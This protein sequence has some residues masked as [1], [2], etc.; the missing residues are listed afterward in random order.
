MWEATFRTG[1]GLTP[2]DMCDWIAT[3]GLPEAVTQT[4]QDNLTSQDIDA[5]TFTDLTTSENGMAALGINDV[6]QRA[7][8]KTL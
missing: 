2:A 8:V 5:L 6:V 7:K 4:V 3:V 1:S